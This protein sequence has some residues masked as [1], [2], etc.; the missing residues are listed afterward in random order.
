MLHLRRIGRSGK[1]R[2]KPIRSGR[3]SLKNY[4][5]TGGGGGLGDAVT[6][7]D[8][9]RFWTE[10][11]RLGGTDVV[12]YPASGRFQWDGFT[13]QVFQRVVLQ[14]RAERGAVEVGNGLE[15]VNGVGYSGGLG[16]RRHRD[17]H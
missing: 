8:G 9:I 17:R 14:W 11:R 10:L 7:N 13:V 5:Q 4:T 6:D 3:L 12:G 1:F 2:V 16:Q 15:R